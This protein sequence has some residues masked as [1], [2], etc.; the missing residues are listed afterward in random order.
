MIVQQNCL[1]PDSLW[2]SKPLEEFNKAYMRKNWKIE[3]NFSRNKYVVTDNLGNKYEFLTSGA[4]PE[5]AE[6]EE[7]G[8]EEEQA[9]TSGPQ[10]SRQRYMRPHREINAD[11][12][13][14]VTM[15]RV[16]SYKNFDRGQQEIYD[17]VSACIGEGREYNRRREAWEG[18]HGPS[19]QEYWAAQEAHRERMNKFVEEQ[20]LFQAMQRSHMEQLAKMQEDEAA[21]RRAW[22]EA[23]ATRRHEERELNQRRWSALY[24]SQQ[25]AVNNAKSPRDIEDD[26]EEDFVPD[27]QEQHNDEDE[28][29]VVQDDLVNQNEAAN[30]PK[31]KKA[32]EKRENWMPKQ[33]EALAKAYVHCILNK[34]KGNQQNSDGFWNQVVRT[35]KKWSS[36][37]LLG[38]DSSGSSQKRKS[39]D[40]GNYKA[41]T[42][43]AEV[44]SGLPDMN[45]DPSPRRQKI[46]EKKD[47]GPSSTSEDPRDITSRFEEYKAMKKELM[48]IKRLRE[49]KYMSLAEEQREALRQTMFDKDLDAFNRP[50]DNVHPSMLEITLARKREIAK[51]YG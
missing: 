38:E 22:E 35:N 28:D 2:V 37:P 11:V 41:D 20:E 8:D 30:D 50:H 43:S 34:R 9:A 42:P 46:K 7:M 19:M 36:V 40:L 47:K 45:E 15:R 12:A 14:F 10:R 17:N 6:D 44:S 27:T 21:R 51:K 18:S 31:G 32:K 13:G 33:E 1:P 5:S 23:E 49:E 39:S 24:V 48:D 16:P 3:I 26:S 29:V 4:P 25:M